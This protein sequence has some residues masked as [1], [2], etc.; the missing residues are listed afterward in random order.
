MRSNRLNLI[1]EFS[2]R[3]PPPRCVRERTRCTFL[4]GY[5]SSLGFQRLRCDLDKAM[6]GRNKSCRG[7]K[8]GDES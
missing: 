2:D 8:Q 4:Q 6:D 7:F 3:D 1:H 5:K